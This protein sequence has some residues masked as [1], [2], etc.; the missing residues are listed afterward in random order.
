MNLN[1]LLNLTSFNTPLADSLIN[2]V[3]TQLTVD[4]PGLNYLQLLNSLMPWTWDEDYPP[5][6]SSSFLYPQDFVGNAVLIVLRKL[7]DYYPENNVQT[8]TNLLKNMVFEIEGSAMELEPGGMP[9]VNFNI[10]II[11][12][13]IR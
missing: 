1:S 7:E 8:G 11:E 6:T 4:A 13:I 10:P 2:I 9:S 12:D 5:L 3:D